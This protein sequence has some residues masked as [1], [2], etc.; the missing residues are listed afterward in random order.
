MNKEILE[1]LKALSL[2]TSEVIRDIAKEHNAHYLELMEIYTD[3]LSEATKQTK[4]LAELLFNKNTD[5]N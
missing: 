3:S 2:A 4:R 1:Q 5:S